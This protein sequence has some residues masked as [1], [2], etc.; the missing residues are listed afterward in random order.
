MTT[1]ANGNIWPNIPVTATPA[2]PYAGPV[3]HAPIVA[4]IGHSYARNHVAK[5]PVVSV[6]R[7]G[8]TVTLAASSSLAAVIGYRYKITGCGSPY[9]ADQV[10]L[11]AVD[12]TNFIYTILQTICDLF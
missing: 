4:L 8:G 6:S 5:T 3:N 10:T 1:D 9:D 7:N 12:N 11:T 2:I